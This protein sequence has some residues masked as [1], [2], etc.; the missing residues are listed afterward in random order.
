[1]RALSIAMK[2]SF[3]ESLLWAV[4]MAWR[5][6]RGSARSIVLF[7][8]SV[9]AGM[10]ALVA[11]SSFKSNLEVEME[12]QQLSLLGA[13]VEYDANQDFSDEVL[14][15]FARVPHVATARETQFETMAYF[16]RSE[17]TRFVRVRAY[18]GAFPFYGK[19]QT[20]PAGLSI[21]DTS[22]P[23]AILEQGL[24]EQ[25][26]L[27]E[28]DFVKLGN[29]R[30]RVVG[31]FSRIP[32]DGAFSGVFLPR[33]L[34][35]MRYVSETGL[36][37]FGSR[38][39]Y[40]LYQKFEEGRKELAGEVV[41]AIRP[42]LRELNVDVDTVADQRR[43]IGS[44]LDNMS[45][46]LSMIGFVALLL[47]GIA[48]AGGVQVYLKEKA[49]S[50]AVLRCLGC[51]ARRAFLV[52][53]LQISA[54][55]L[56]GAT[57]GTALGSALQFGMPH[58]VGSFL[59]I[60]VAVA[61][62]L[63]SA[64]R[65]LSFGW[66]LTTLLALL[67][68]LPLRGISPLR[69]IRAS[70]ESQNGQGSYRAIKD[71]LLWLIA[72]SALALATGFAAFETSNRVVALAFI[73]GVGVA[74]LLLWALARGMRFA[75]RRVGGEGLPYAVRLGISS[76]YRPNNRT[77]LLSI[78][79]GMG[80][81]LI[82]GVFLIQQSILKEGELEDGDD[83]FNLVFFDVQ[84]DQVAGVED[85]VRDFG[86]EI[87]LTT[88]MVT[89]R[90]TEINGRS[91]RSLREDPSV[92]MESW[93]LRREYRS[94][95][96]DALREDETLLSGQF[97]G[98]RSYGGEG[99]V[100]PVSVEQRM[101]EAL[102]LRLGDRLVFDVQG[103]LIATEVASIREVDWRQMKLNFFVVFPAGV[104]EAAPKT[105]ITAARLADPEGLIELQNKVAG[106]FPNV[107][108][109][110]LTVVLQTLGDLLD[111]IGF[112]VRFMASFTLLTGVV[113]LVASVLS[114][115]YQRIREMALLRTIGASA[116]QMGVMMLVEFALIGL[117]A[118]LA[119]VA[120]SFLGSWAVAQ[121]VFR[122][123]L[124]IPWGATLLAVLL[125]SGLTLGVGMLNSVGV[126]RR[127]PMESIRS[128]A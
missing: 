128:E 72:S 57:L 70:V 100:V 34:I 88:P 92:E 73:A 85:L 94:T 24:F 116:R 67:P 97:I 60:D 107:S 91:A 62:D 90:I 40:T 18:E 45:S 14:E 52:F 11:I 37:Q 51:S 3:A 111:K 86:A 101:V 15:L 21:V 54:I 5:D 55:G 41:E 117:I 31:S 98:Q 13:D 102:G 19:M 36:D 4:T 124:Y 63:G 30:F 96:S 50:I 119:G 121:F 7:A 23:E 38:M 12:R 93:A 79:L 59:P 64:L 113:A 56:G 68:L 123:T 22:E 2:T 77:T 8:L 1:M 89:M 16:E 120:L 76:L 35:S 49:D 48:I 118:G 39:R 46:F 84:E 28:G 127:S 25:L 108:A 99:D 29:A 69:A 95:Y 26:A 17:Q 43:R 74:V 80:T 122:I 105:F 114:S 66:A 78:V 109:I 103:I 27:Q 47:G 81:F 6:M 58:V 32:G 42:Q 110:N 126:A 44:S 104:L 82:F 20:K 9:V 65:S 112:V 115:R 10:T 33:A 87:K 75:L 125:A 83:Q 106:A 71:P 61:W 53:A